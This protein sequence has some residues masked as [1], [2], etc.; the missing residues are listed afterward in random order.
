M[1]KWKGELMRSIKQTGFSALSLISSLA[2]QISISAFFGV[3]DQLSD[4]LSISAL[5]FMVGGVIAGAINYGMLSSFHSISQKR[6]LFEVSNDPY[7]FFSFFLLFILIASLGFGLDLLIYKHFNVVT[8]IVWVTS[9][10]IALNGYL[11]VIFISNDSYTHSSLSGVVL[12]LTIVSFLLITQKN[13]TIWLSYSYLIGNLIVAIYLFSRALRYGFISL[14]SVKLQFDFG[15]YTKLILD[16]AVVTIVFA[17]VP[18]FDS[19]FYL[20]VES[21]TLAEVSYAYKMSTSIASLLAVGPFLVFQRK[22]SRTYESDEDLYYKELFYVILGT[23]L[24]QYIMAIL[25]TVVRV[26]L[27]GI[28]YERGAFNEQ[29]VTSVSKIFPFYLFGGCYMVG[30]TLIFRGLF[31]RNLTVYTRWI[32]AFFIIVYLTGM[33]TLYYHPSSMNFAL[34][35]MLSWH[36]TFLFS[37][38]VFFKKQLKTQKMFKF[39]LLFQLLI[40]IFTVYVLIS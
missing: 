19:L 18:W 38:A 24:V 27:L 30:V 8:L 36:L 10:F 16:G 20:I 15:S 1:A 35:Y 32:M 28:V 7:R 2:L 5:P 12:N 39:A 22:L 17:I 25:F 34:T 37:F 11:L 14:N 23:F 21:K 13:S 31:L 4:F 26:D 3:S 29:A 40:F 9:V 33:A 6:Q